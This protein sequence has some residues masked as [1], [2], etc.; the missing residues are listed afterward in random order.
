M[1]MGSLYAGC[2]LMTIQTRTP[3]R[4]SWPVTCGGHLPTADGRPASGSPYQLGKGLH[5]SYSPYHLCHFE[6][7]R[8][9]ANT[10]VD[11]P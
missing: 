6:V 5:S 10:Q 11:S 7:P 4:G 8:L 1:W 2:A 9:A 3:H